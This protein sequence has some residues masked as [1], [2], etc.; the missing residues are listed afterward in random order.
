[1][2][3]LNLDKMAEGKDDG[4]NVQEMEKIDPGEASTLQPTNASNPASHSSTN[5]NTNPKAQASTHVAPWQPSRK[6]E[7][8]SVWDRIYNEKGTF[9]LRLGGKSKDAAKAKAARKRLKD[10]AKAVVYKRHGMTGEIARPSYRWRREAEMHPGMPP[11]AISQILLPRRAFRAIALAMIFMR[12]TQK[13]AA[14]KQRR[15]IKEERRDLRDTLQL[16]RQVVQKWLLGVVKL[17]LS[18]IATNTKLAFH[19]QA[20]ASFGHSSRRGFSRLLGVFKGSKS[21]GNGTD[22]DPTTRKYM[23]IKVRLRGVL[24]ELVES[25]TI[26]KG[27]PPGI[28]ALLRRIISDRNYFPASFLFESETEKL[29][30]D[31]LGGTRWMVGSAR[32]DK[33][34]GESE[35]D[36]SRCKLILINYLI[37]RILLPIIL[38]PRDYGVVS[39]KVSKVVQTNLK[40]FASLVYVLVRRLVG[41]IDPGVKEEEG[42]DEKTKTAPKGSARNVLRQ[43][44]LKTTKKK[45]TVLRNASLP[46]I[47]IV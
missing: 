17:P 6:G 46:A 35:H 22:E 5:I 20:N 30:F 27:M 9:T 32:R 36:F 18:S 26:E 15:F 2:P 41:G 44:S 8:E 12:R 3:P 45:R 38:N 10:A 23:T 29:D 28:V 39:R 4:E 24:D 14:Q 21:K 37:V 33:L 42:D 34:T 16:Y 13:Q 11:P 25:A 7:E 31:D 47:I 43:A 19:P 1:M 40:V